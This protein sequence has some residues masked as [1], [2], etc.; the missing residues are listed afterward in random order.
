MVPFKQIQSRVT[1]F[2]LIL[3][4]VIDKYDGKNTGSQTN[5]RAKTGQTYGKTGTELKD[6]RRKDM[7]I[8]C[9]DDGTSVIIDTFGL[10]R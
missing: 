2:L 8:I 10:V 9:S 4:I 7:I 1:I 6:M 3:E 5:L